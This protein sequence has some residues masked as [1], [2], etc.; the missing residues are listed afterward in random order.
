MFSHDS[1][2]WSPGAPRRIL[3]M[4]VW[5]VLLLAGIAVMDCVVLVVGLAI[6]LGGKPSASP[7]Q[8]S[9][10]SPPVPAG[11]TV[12]PTLT[13]S[14]S[15]TPLTMVFQFPTYTPYGTPP[16]TPT[17][18]PTYTQLMTGWARFYTPLVE[19]WM[20]S[21]YAA[22]N[23]H[24]EA[25]AIIA[26]LKDKG[27]EFDWENLETRMDD[28]GDTI[29][30]WGV[31]SRR[32]IPGVVTEVLVSYDFPNP[33]EPLADYANRFI[34]RVSDTFVVI[35][36]RHVPHP[37]YELERLIMETK[38]VQGIPVRYALYAAREKNIVWDIL[39]ATASDEM[40][41]RLI[42][43]DLMVQSFR[44]LSSPG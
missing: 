10:S 13:P 38:D 1:S 15:E 11:L 29:V 27:A 44:S 43:F 34:G 42:E 26:S 9:A 31:D 33:G 19:M 28:A 24:I 5:Q 30:F 23:P 12:A 18:T 25:N 16:D 4:K 20:P 36:Q 41:D 7:E 22:G 14:P 6:V 32:G 3:G 21:S 2:G 40:N 35:E 37:L 17:F 8:A 39:C